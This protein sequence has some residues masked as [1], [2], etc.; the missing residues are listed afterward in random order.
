[1]H[2]PLFRTVLL[3]SAVFAITLSGQP[4]ND[5]V[6]VQLLAFNDFHGHLEPPS[7]SNGVI[8]STPAGGAEYL[9]SHLRTLSARNPNTLIVSAGDT[10]GASPLLSGMFH[11]EPAI[12]ALNA[13]GL[14][15]SSV[16]NHEFDDGWREL[17][18][19]QNG[20]CHPV[21]GC[22]DNTPFTGATFQ[23][24]AAN[25]TF[26]RR[27]SDRSGSVLPPYVIKEVGGVPIGFI[28]LTLRSTPQLVLRSGIEE[29][30]F[31]PEAATANTWVRALKKVNVEAIVVLIHEGG[32][33]ARDDHNA[34]AG[35][36]GP[37]VDI[38]DDMSDDVDV[39]ISG[40]TH[41]AYNC[42]IDGRVVTSAA[43][44]GRVVTA[45]DLHIDRRTGD[46]TSKSARNV[47]VTRDVP[48]DLAQ[49]AL[50]EHY[51]PFYATVA[52]KIVGTLGADM[53][54]TPTF[55]GESALGDM[56]ADV[57]LEAARRVH[58]A[59]AEI[60][61]MNPGGIR[62]DF[63]RD[64]AGTDAVRPITYAEAS[65]VLPFRNRIVSQTMTGEAIKQV[66]EQQFDNIAPGE[67]RMLQ[68]SDGFSYTYDRTA[69]KSRRVIPNSITIGGRP[70]V[71]RQR[72]RVALN[73]F[74]AA[75][76]DNFSAFTRATDVVTLG[77]DLDA[78]L[79]YLEVHSPIRP[80]RVDRITR[81]K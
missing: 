10:I 69:P 12:E 52:N 42:F 2:A 43:A 9:A 35:V 40:H 36:S 79:E 30:R 15:V 33:P 32:V 72:Y 77:M 63:A 65:T 7:G 71:P 53:R 78:L 31:E 64:Q 6:A 56:L 76:G 24:L 29:L 50:I 55:A 54:R 44:F 47:I 37:I 18:R 21:D 11:D 17:L 46:V 28:G 5:D 62:A 60:A 61:F 81:T 3:L 73:E 66:L 16:G 1:V 51:R 75:G 74:I 70:L 27:K 34:C 48:R 45:I 49:T 23:Y 41:R 13:M 22:P 57:A 14:A 58:G 39:V 80:G 20:G 59:G 8:G 68:I 67:D 26:D 4:H 25:V 19:M 38:V